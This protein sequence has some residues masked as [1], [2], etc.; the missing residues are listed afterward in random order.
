M[1]NEVEPLRDRDVPH[2]VAEWREG[3]E[4]GDLTPLDYLSL[5]Q[6]LAFTIAAQWLFCP[7]FVE[8][9]G[10]VVVVKDGDDE[11]NLTDEHKKTIDDWLDYFREDIPSTEVKANLL[12]LSGVFTGFGEIPKEYDLYLLALARSVAR[13]WEGLLAVQFP[14]RR[15]TVEVYGDSVSEL[16][17]EITFY[18]TSTPRATVT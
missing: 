7:N 8:Y 16:D 1:T 2:F 12:H 6:G 9:R 13:C 14:D 18:T 3:F 11:G 10:C 4:P 15:F 17:P 5:D